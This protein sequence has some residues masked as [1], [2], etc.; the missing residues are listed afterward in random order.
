MMRKIISALKCQN[1]KILKRWF[2]I[3]PLDISTHIYSNVSICL[4]NPSLW[5]MSDEMTIDHG[6]GEY[7]DQCWGY[8]AHVWLTNEVPPAAAKMI[9]Y[10]T[11]HQ[12]PHTGCLL[13]CWVSSELVWHGEEIRGIFSTFVIHFL[14]IFTHQS[15]LSRGE[16]SRQM[17]KI[18]W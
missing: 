14:F 6:D 11:A 18:R 9:T 15:P 2:D 13:G 7:W 8:R 10:L 17:Y 16:H 4:R 3:V 5:K 12:P 1:T